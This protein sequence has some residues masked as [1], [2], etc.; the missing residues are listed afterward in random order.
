[1][2]KS[3]WPGGIEP[4]LARHLGAGLHGPEVSGHSYCSKPKLA[5]LYTAQVLHNEI[6]TSARKFRLRMTTRHT[7]YNELCELQCDFYMKKRAP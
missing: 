3:E 1:M 6:T 5:H 2:K 7:I 4:A